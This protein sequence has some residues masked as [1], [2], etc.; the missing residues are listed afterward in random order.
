MRPAYSTFLGLFIYGFIVDEHGLSFVASTK[1]FLSL[2]VISGLYGLTDK[3]WRNILAIAALFPIIML[4]IKVYEA[5][6]LT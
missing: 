4:L 5:G 1:G 6:L 3:R 2:V